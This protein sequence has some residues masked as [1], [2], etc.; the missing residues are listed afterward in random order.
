MGEIANVFIVLSFTPNFSCMVQNHPL[1]II[2]Q[3]I[4]DQH[5]TIRTRGYYNLINKRTKPRKNKENY[6]DHTV[7]LYPTL[8][9]TLFQTN[10]AFSDNHKTETVFWQL[11]PT[12]CMVSDTRSFT[13]Y[14]SDLFPFPHYR[15]GE[16][17]WGYNLEAPSRYICFHSYS[18]TWL[19]ANKT[20]DILKHR[21]MMLMD[22][23]VMW[24]I[25]RDAFIHVHILGWLQTTLKSWI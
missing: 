21:R 22:I 14:S 18:H 10:A 7:C 23:C 1:H 17:S 3:W 9:T 19:A 4:L 6:Y 20:K 24:N 16:N 13:A 25:L 15:Q 12:S 8:H 2:P 11:I 5:C